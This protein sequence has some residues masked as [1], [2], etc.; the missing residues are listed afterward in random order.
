[1]KPILTVTDAPCLV[2]P[3]ADKL[4]PGL[5][6]NRGILPRNDQG[7][8]S[9]PALLLQRSH[10]GHPH[11]LEQQ[12]QQHALRDDPDTRFPS[13]SPTTVTTT[14]TTTTTTNAS[15]D[16]KVANANTTT[17]ITNTT[18]TTNTTV[19]VYALYESAA[20]SHPVQAHVDFREL[21]QLSA[22]DTQQQ[23]QQQ[24]QKQYAQPTDSLGALDGPFSAAR[25]C[26]AAE[27]SLDSLHQLGCYAISLFEVSLSM[28]STRGRDGGML[29]VS[30][31]TV[32]NRQKEQPIFLAENCPFDEK[33]GRLS[34]LMNLLLT[35]LSF[36]EFNSS[37]RNESGLHSPVRAA[38]PFWGQTTF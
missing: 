21:L 31:A 32:H 11:A 4:C 8:A 14:T 1:M 27:R 5:L 12:Q 26:L 17:T 22:E 2:S 37:L 15:T 3:I 13:Q 23:Q 25:V 16:A 24:R 19:N 18:T 7:V 38:V 6:E 35:P 36:Q 30:R 34:T 20:P 33:E 28:G 29:G 10:D 9:I